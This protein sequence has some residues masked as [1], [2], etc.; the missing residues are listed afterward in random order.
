MVIFLLLFTSRKSFQSISF[1]LRQTKKTHK[2]EEEKVEKN[3]K[4]EKIFS[5]VLEH[6][7]V[8]E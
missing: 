2:I 5:L 1:S 4:R 7:M 3:Y 6:I 8:F